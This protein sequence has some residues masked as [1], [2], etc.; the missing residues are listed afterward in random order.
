MEIEKLKK[1]KRLLIV[2]DM[3]N[4]FV[5]EGPL[6]DP[7]IQT[8]VPE[9]VRLVEEF[10]ESGD[11]VVAFK[12]AHEKGCMEFKYF[13][14]HCLKGTKESELIDELKVYENR[15]IV[16]EKNSTSGFM[17]PGFI[18]FLKNL[19]MLIEMVTAGCEIDH[20]VINFDIP[21]KNYFNENN[22]DVNVIVPENAVETYDA[23]WH[24]REE[25]TDMA[26][27]L[28]KQ[29]GIQLVKRYESGGKNV[30]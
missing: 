13:P 24:N 23:P 27:K 21:A 9:I 7:H 25:Y 17:V 6:A 12:D 11:I 29:S 1:A 5:K 14:E 2:I 28:M 16:F 10:L 20:C 15:M 4:G 18:D 19:K 8:I 30:K 3:I 26:F 22:R